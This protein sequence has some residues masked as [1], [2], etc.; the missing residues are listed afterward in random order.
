MVRV[1]TKYGK[2]CLHQV[3][4]RR[5]KN[6]ELKTKHGV[7]GL[8]KDAQHKK[9]Y[10]CRF[11]ISTCVSR[12]TLRCPGRDIDF[13]FF[14]RDFFFYP[15]LLFLSATSF[16]YPRLLL[17]CAT[18]FF[19]RDSFF[20]SATSFVFIPDLCFACVKTAVSLTLSRAGLRAGN[21]AAVMAGEDRE[22]EEQ[23]AI[24]KVNMLSNLWY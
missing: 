14:I 13:F 2:Q 4:P 22:E 18:S 5:T 10:H 15:W 21:M 6:Q 16:F 20:L 7:S 8:T 9:S 17:L 23:G 24:R 3:E 12:T 11:Q 1:V 19:I